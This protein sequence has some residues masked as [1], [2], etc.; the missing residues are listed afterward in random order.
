MFE[1]NNKGHDIHEVKKVAFMNLHWKEIKEE[2]DFY[3]QQNKRLAVD[4]LL[5]TV[6]RKKNKYQKQIQENEVRIERLWYNFID[7]P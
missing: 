2:I 1:H 6:F 3:Q 5:R 4:D 7:F